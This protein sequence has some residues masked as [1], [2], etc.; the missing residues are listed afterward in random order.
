[1]Y[2]YLLTMSTSII[3]STT[4]CLACSSS[5]P[6]SKS[7]LSL[8]TTACCNRP[9]CPQCLQSNPRL[10]RYNPCLA[11]L[12]GVGAINAASRNFSAKGKEAVNSNVDGAIRDED[13]FAIG[14]D[15]DEEEE[16]GAEASQSGPPPP[17]S[18]STPLPAPAEEPP[19]PQQLDT[20]ANTE[21]GGPNVSE[22][23]SQ[24]AT[25]EEN[26]GSNP[27]K[28]YIKPSDNLQG[29][30]L[31]FGLKVCSLTIPL[32]DILKSTFAQGRDLCRLNNLPPSTLT[33]TPHLLHT[34]AFLTLPPSARTHTN[35]KP[36]IDKE[37][38]ARIAKERAEKRLQTLT[39]EVDWRVAK[40]YVALADDDSASGSTSYLGLKSKEASEVR[41]RPGA[42]TSKGEGSRT[43]LEA[44]AVDR[45]LDDEEWE[46]EERKAGRGVLVRSFPYASFSNDVGKGKERS[47]WRWG[48]R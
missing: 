10:A 37:R 42:G 15:S 23:H 30:A 7:S 4:L 13:N 36:E 34:R 35:A 25:P 16:D 41:K 3:S 8:F 45:Y 6:P 2:R 39:K 29:I 9:I 40:A 22:T 21:G 11:C 31:R 26:A 20:G 12:G 28:Y 5:L 17:Y 14:D 46:E 32:G 47:F 44:N 1:M 18:E 43:E 24:P 48:S 38:E 27:S 33:T 19:T